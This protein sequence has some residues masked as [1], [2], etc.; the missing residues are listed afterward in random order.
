MSQQTHHKLKILWAL[1]WEKIQIQN[2]KYKFTE[3]VL[4]SYHQSLK[5]VSQTI[6]D[7]I[8]LYTVLED[9]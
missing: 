9:T 3:C 8:H 1:A 2:L 6:M 7:Q 5:I 4:V